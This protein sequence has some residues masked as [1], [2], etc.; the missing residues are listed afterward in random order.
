MRIPGGL[1]GKEIEFTDLARTG[2]DV[3]VRVERLDGTE[4]LERILPVDPAFTLMP[5]PG[6]LDVVTTYTVLGAEH[7]IAG[8]DHLLF[9]LATFNIVQVPGPPVE[10][11]IDFLRFFF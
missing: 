6:P 11:I 3:L 2:L 4:R 1:D 9:V 10:A 8:F 5:S 7:I